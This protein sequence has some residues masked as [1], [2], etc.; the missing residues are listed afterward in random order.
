MLDE[1]DIALDSLLP[2]CETERRTSNEGW[3]S[4]H[5]YLYHLAS[6][7]IVLGRILG[8]KTINSQL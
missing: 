8:S 4:Y 2:V 6:I 5:A 1:H 7:G 3:L